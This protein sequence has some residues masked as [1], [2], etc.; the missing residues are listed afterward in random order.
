M[1]LGER[2]GGL[3][4]V[5]AVVSVQHH[6]RA[7]RYALFE[8]ALEELVGLRLVLGD[9]HRLAKACLRIDEGRFVGGPMRPFALA[10]SLD[11]A[12]A[13]VDQEG[14]RP[15]Q[16]PEPDH[17]AD[18]DQGRGMQLGLPVLGQPGSVLGVRN[19]EPIEDAVAVNE[20]IRRL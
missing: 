2:L 13:A 7:V 12:L 16:Q 3:E 5:G 15:E 14:D 4:A 20:R 11:A 1:V 10:G 19:D 6:H 8:V 17:E 9:L 18:R